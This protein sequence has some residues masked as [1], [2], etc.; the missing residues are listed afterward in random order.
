[1][2]SVAAPLHL[3]HRRLAAALGLAALAAFISG[4]GI[5]TPTPLIAAGALMLALVWAPGARLQ[6]V[7]DPVWRILA[8]VLTARALYRIITSPEDVVLP[9]V[10][11]LLVLLVSE[12]MR[13]R[14]AAG[15]TRVY[16]LSFALL[17]ASCAY[18]PG[19]VFALSFIAYAAL[20]T[21]TLMVGHLIRKLSEHHARDV[22][23]DRWFLLR[24]AGLSGVMLALSAVF[25]VGFP[26][27][28]RN[29]VMRT[30]AQAASVVGFSDRVS[31]AEHGS[32]IQSNPE[33]VLR[34]E[35][36]MGAPDDAGVLYW[37]GRSYDLFDGVAWHRSPTLPRSGSS[38]A[39]YGGRWPGRRVLQRIYAVP[40]EIPVL[41]GLHPIL[42]VRPQS[43]LRALQDNV[44]DMWYFGT[45]TP[46]YDVVS[47][48][49]LPAPEKL[50]LAVGSPLAAAEFYLQL[51]PLS[52]RIRALADSLTAGRATRYD[53]VLAVQ[54]WLR[55]QFRY[56]LDLPATPREATLEHFLFRRRAGHC[57]YFSTALAI[58][59]RAEGIPA[60]NVNGFL[61]GTWNEFGGF[62]TVSQ[63]EAHSWV[64][65]YFSGYG[66][67]PFDATPAATADVAQIQNRWA[68]PFRSLIDGLE[69]RWNKWILEYNLEK[70]VS[71]FRRAT[72]PFARRDSTGRLR[73]SPTLTRVLTYALGGA[74][75]V[76]LL[77]TLFKHVRLRDMPPESQVYLKLRQTYARAG[78]ELHRHDAPMKFVERLEL[79]DAP[80]REAARRAIELYL[81]SRFGGEDIGAAGQRELRE[82]ANAARRALRAA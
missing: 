59:L 80:G 41:F 13:E 31:L 5:E 50:R 43:Q 7:L 2:G 49:D 57:E 1:V 8:L 33:I 6:R 61:G 82:A 58:L 20:A 67:I 29:W 46:I 27:V 56:T 70:Q 64:E 45:A 81:R 65:V 48:I 14:G 63:N 68:G 73:V 62:V 15:D 71:L 3:L 24:V 34:V 47:A 76:L 22:A 23:L 72:E 60:R 79:A 19:F 11:L 75:L 38:P 28:S 9:M 36:P 53:A 21:V 10:D 54:N 4:A 69:H 40:L 66:W 26:R 78:Y 32:R 12:T 44:G 17:V 30:T 35:F 25:F 55:T 51:P 39:I 77:G 18:R 42:N 74:A 52:D 37:R 16:S